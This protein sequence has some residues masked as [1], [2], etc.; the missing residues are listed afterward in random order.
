MASK[1]DI[2]RH[3]SRLWYL[4]P[5]FLSLIGGLI[6]YFLVRSSDATIAKNSLFIGITITA[7]SCAIALAVYVA[8]VNDMN[9]VRARISAS[10]I[11]DTS[12]GKIEYADVGQGNPILSIHGA[13]GGFDQGLITAE[14]FFDEETLQNH[15]VI[16]P[17]RFGY[18]KTPL[19]AGDAGPAAQADA[20]A[21]LLNALR[22]D[23]KVIVLG[24]S[25]GALS[26]QE[27]AIKYPERVS[28]LILA[29]PAV[30]TPESAAEGSAEIGSDNFIANIVM[31][32]DFAMWV[33][34]KVAYGQLLTYVGVPESLQE[35][36]TEQEKNDAKKLMDAILPV[37]QK[38]DGGTQEAAN[39]ANKERLALESIRA[40]TI[41]IDAKDVV[42]YP[43]SKYAAEHI[44]N[45]EFVA[46]E[47]GGHLL[48]GHG[49][50]AKKAISDFL[51]QHKTEK[52]SIPQ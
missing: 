11:I 42:T 51:K 14:A 20:H 45:A 52:P 25:A 4:L 50:D 1:S 44:P 38:V 27:F 13:G 29:V 10:K 24:T 16:T 28:A 3:R 34:T 46:F 33:F 36:M 17:S 43:G 15:R 40:P 21:A 8:Y 2:Q 5:I 22:I 19:P 12:M 32:S 47:T 6:A 23:E 26:A 18:L 49:D 48:I 9:V 39:M 31:R 41:V 37:S 7:V 30:W 35:K